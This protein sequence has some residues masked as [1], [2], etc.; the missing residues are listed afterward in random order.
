MKIVSSQI[1][2]AA[3]VA[4]AL[5]ASP[6]N[7]K[8]SKKAMSPAVSE[9]VALP[10]LVTSVEGIDEYR[11]PNG[12]K[13][14]LFPDASKPTF[15]VN[16]TYLVGS[17][18]EN[19]GET[20]MAHL[21]E[22]LVFKGTPTHKE[23]PR[24]FKER[25]ANFNASTALDRTNYYAQLT[26]SDENLVW[27][28]GLEADRMVNSYIAQKDLD[29]EMTVVRNEYESGE[30]SPNRVMLKRLQSIAYDW[31]SYGR[32]TIGNRSDIENVKIENLQAFYR[33]YYQ[34]DNATVI[35][36]GKFD[37]KLAL[38][39]L[40]ET[41]GKIPKPQRVLP[42]QWTVEPT[43]DGERNFVVRRKDELQMIW[44][45]Y[46]IPSDLHADTLALGAAETVLG[47]T[48]TGRIHKSLIES[49]KAASQFH[50]SLSGVAPG[51]ILFATVVKNGEAV[52]PVRD[53]LIDEI[54]NFYKNPATKE[55]LDRAKL[56]ATKDAERVMTRH[57]L[58]GPTLSEAVALGDWRVYFQQRD[59]YQL[60]SSD[61]LTRVAQKY[62][63]RDNRTVGIYLPE[64][65]PNR[66]DVPTAPTLAEVMKDFK[67]KA[68]AAAGE[69]FDPSPQNLDARTHLS[70]M[71]DIKLAML[72]KKNRGETVNVSIDFKWGDEKTRF[73]KA[74]IA[75]F[76]S[77][78]LTRG[79]ADM[80]R[81]QIADARDKLK[82]TGGVAN[83][84]TTRANLAEALRLTAKILRT[85][86]FPENEF[87]QFKK[88]SLAGLEAARNDP[89]TLGAIAL[90]QHFN[91]Y[92][93]GDPRYTPSLDES[94]ADMQAVTLEQV[95]AYHAEFYG[96]STGEISIVGDF[97]ETQAVQVLKEVFGDWK[98]QRPYARV[99]D[100]F[101]ANKATRLKVDTPDKENAY[102]SARLGINMTDESP[103][104]ADMLVVNVIMGSSGLSSRL[105]DRI[106]QKDGLSYSVNSQFSAPAESNEANWSVSA[107]AAPQNAA[108]VEA[109]MRDE[110]ARAL[111]DGFTAAEVAAAI[112]NLIK[113]N[114]RARA[115][116]SAVAATWN[117][118]QFL[119]RSF[120]TRSAKVDQDIKNVTPASAVAAMR[121]YI[122]PDELSVVVA[123]DAKKM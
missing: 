107:I 118:F 79:T 67:P 81:T 21:L 92:P 100:H 78:L 65:T 59:A 22:H 104:Y 9:P 72:P 18:H 13:V 105:G 113:S 69:T 76:T 19:Y 119:G 10:T 122:K 12:L 6:L 41:F 52:E 28:L 115:Q 94:L 66:I 103:D 95:K 62:F 110:L 91:H 25:G 46:K 15:T 74:T 29:T 49:G 3:F 82:I 56:N 80:T 7:A 11:L 30:T 68:A 42:V 97:D 87:T 44:V 24:E 35:V 71:G 39:T 1:L 54:E 57:D 111:K 45:A 73:N 121:K 112:D 2:V 102:F 16:V 89:N 58:L 43:Q 61:D 63:R 5:A 123:G 27:A 70:K 101:E 14:L 51:L 99:L 85:A 109:A 4:L 32:S 116:D 40:T 55:E 53:A 33:T 36:A 108:K 23:I 117:R 77:A 96:A 93:K 31:H 37:P 86:S 84:E 47:D 114:Q 106:R 34:P 60:L 48:P 120:V 90:A 75:S 83:F 98:S 20:G 50:Y 88:Q 8:E 26:A 38:K 64:A 17:R